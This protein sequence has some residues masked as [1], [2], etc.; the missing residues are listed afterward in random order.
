MSGGLFAAPRGRL[1][2]A[3]VALGLLAAV[4]GCSTSG[5]FNNLA[6]N[7][8]FSN[9]PPVAST[10]LGTGSIKVGLLLPL[11]AEGAVGTLADN[12][13]NAADLALRDF[14][15]ANIQLLVEDDGGTP[16]GARAGTNQAVAAGAQLVLGPLFADSVPAA[17]SAA[18]NV[19]VI[20]FSTDTSKISRGVY[21]LSF[22]PQNDV[23]R[24]VA[25][26]AS[27]G[28]RTFAAI[29]PNT[30]SGTLY[31]QEFQR[32]V[33]NAGGQVVG[34]EHYDIDQTS[35]QQA[36]TALAMLIN[37]SKIDAVFM[38]DS[39]DS[40]PFL[41]QIVAANGVKRGKVTYL[42]SGQWNDPRVIKETNLDGGWYPGPDNSS[43]AAFAQRYK[44]AFGAQP[45][46]NA[47]LAYDAVSLAAGLSSKYGAGAFAPQ[48]LTDTN[49]FI[50]VD[51]AFRLNA[52]GTSQ[53][54]LAIYEINLSKTTV[55][56]AAPRTFVR[57]GA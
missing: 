1:A 3:A 26:A 9:D 46:R 52:D 6:L 50:G 31:E 5:G 55:V 25:Y 29:L 54:G 42:G 19:P 13:K 48:V 53:R 14:P 8:P 44:A 30:A 12:L 16:Q 33:S 10:T 4:T 11:S 39:G 7:N 32:A 18:R 37:S 40:T 47:T 43:F 51:G 24:I 36:A 20:A 15:N 23:D 28:K 21:L 22:L 41:A 45:L 2:G 35:M 17:A 57:P 49:G 56:D 27:K 34:I 38:P